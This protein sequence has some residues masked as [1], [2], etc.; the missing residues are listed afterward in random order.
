M[1]QQLPW[2]KPSTTEG[3]CK[4]PSWLSLRKAQKRAKGRGTALLSPSLKHPNKANLPCPSQP[5]ERNSWPWRVFLLLC[6]PWLRAAIR[7]EYINEEMPFGGWKT[8]HCFDLSAVSVLKRGLEKFK[9]L[10][11]SSSR[12]TKTHPK[13]GRGLRR[14]QTCPSRVTADMTAGRT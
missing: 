9:G 2:R 12:K 1:E 11:D 4:L 8:L 13:A 3:R 5:W 14:K 10:R 7:A 6:V